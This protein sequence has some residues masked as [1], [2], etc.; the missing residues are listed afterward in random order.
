MDAA[1]HRARLIV[2]LRPRVVASV[3]AVLW[4]IGFTPC[5]A[6]FD[7]TPFVYKFSQSASQWLPGS[8][9]PHYAAVARNSVPIGST[10]SYDLSDSGKVTMDFSRIVIGRLVHGNCVR[11]SKANRG[12]ARCERWVDGARLT[13]SASMGRNTLHF[14]GRINRTKALA[15]GRYVV[16]I[17][18]TEPFYETTSDPKSLRFTILRP[19]G[20]NG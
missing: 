13:H 10:F 16:E 20:G 6:A 2:G 12:R 7:P 1:T 19:T 9:L 5:A 14:E 18:I 3:L 17:T 15:P 11:P 8:A 4:S